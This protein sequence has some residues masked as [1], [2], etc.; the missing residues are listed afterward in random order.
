MASLILCNKNKSSANFIK[1]KIY[2]VNTLTDTAT[3]TFAC[4]SSSSQSKKKYSA[5]EVDELIVFFPL[6]YIV[7]FC[8]YWFSEIR[9][10]EAKICLNCQ[11]THFSWFF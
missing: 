5:V 8:R 6:H 7:Q 10:S 3:F 4:V 1:N 11:E 9:V 2:S